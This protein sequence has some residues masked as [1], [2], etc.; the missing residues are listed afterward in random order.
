MGISLKNN[1]LSWKLF[2]EVMGMFLLLS[3]AFTIFQHS[4]E[5][6]FKIEILNNK[7]Q[8]CNNNLIKSAYINNADYNKLNDFILTT[9]VEGLRISIIDTDGNVVA[10]SRQHNPETLDN[11]LNRKE[12]KETLQKGSGYDVIRS[13]VSFQDRYFYS[14]TLCKEKNL[15]IRSAIPYDSIAIEDLNTGNSF[16]YFAIAITILMGIILFRYTRRIGNHIRYLKLFAIKAERGERLDADM[17]RKLPD[18]ELGEISHTIIQLYWKLKHSEEDK[19]RLKRQ[20]TQNA[21]HELK[22]PAAT[23]QGYLETIINTP[24]IPEEK[25]QYFLERCYSQSKRMSKLLQDMST[26]TKLD[27]INYDADQPEINLLQIIN[28][29][30]DD[31]AQDLQAKG[32]RPIIQVPDNFYV[33]ADSSLLYSV[34]RNL[35]DNTISYSAIATKITVSAAQSN[36]KYV[37]SFADNGIG[38]ESQHLA[39]L[40]ERFYR[41]DK[42]RSRKA[43]GT[44]LGLAIVKNAVMVHGGTIAAY[45][46]SG[47]GLT[48]EFTLNAKTALSEQS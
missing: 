40:F 37:I 46:T 8:N 28:G 9:S 42:G 20:L 41:V 13:S 17:Q 16:L 35:I 47:G 33:K 7:L 15:I 1:R 12:V 2:I 44:G 34:F 19:I 25:K 18:D 5:R 45:H 6:K 48:I 32:I 43:G 11:H 10:D 29:A 4:R 38:V 31:Y 27:E 39:R 24:D 21:A 23:I 36:D 14:A 3:L 26:L 22:T 30:F